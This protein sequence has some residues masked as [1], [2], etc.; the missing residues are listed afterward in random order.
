M[1]IGRYGDM[2]RVAVLFVAVLVLGLAP[3]VGSAQ[4]LSTDGFQGLPLFSGLSAFGGILGGP[5]VA[6]RGEGPF[7]K[8]ITECYLGYMEHRNGTG[9]DLATKSIPLGDVNKFSHHYPVRG[10]W[11]G[12]SETINLSER[13]GL[14]ASGW[15]L[16]PS[17]RADTE[18]YNDGEASRNWNTRNEWWYVDGLAAFTPVAGCSLLVG[19]RYD[20]FTTEFRNPFA[21][22]G[23]ISAPTD[24]ADVIAHN[25]IPLVGVQSAYSSAH[26]R[27]LFRAV[28]F[29]A[30]LGTVKY[31]QAFESA[32]SVE[33][34][35]NYKRGYYLEFF[36]QYV[37]EFG[38]A[39]LGVFA[40]WGGTRG[41]ANLDTTLEGTV[42]GTGNATF[43]FSLNR[44][45]WTVGGSVSLKFDLPFV[46]TPFM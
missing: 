37:R 5:S 12:L 16:L 4:G 30:L 25:W 8:G 18:I 22:L 35:G 29:P 43:D 6:A 24:T 39:E 40:R 14:V 13:I 10:V 32:N 45:A 42:G 28:G 46:N 23:I 26:S 36:T 7:P 34:T 31:R 21:V 11:L 41:E 2:K 9:F 27:L 15:Y 44:H 1:H 38:P 3:T 19:V 33:A 20:Q 17:N